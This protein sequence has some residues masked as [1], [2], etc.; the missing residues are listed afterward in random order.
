MTFE[1]ALRTETEHAKFFAEAL[2][3]LDRPKGSGP[4]TYY[5]CTVCGFTTTDLN[6]N[7]CPNCFKPKDRYK[8]VS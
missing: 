6:F 2:Q 8:A 1:N 7:K 3:N 4:R 5:V